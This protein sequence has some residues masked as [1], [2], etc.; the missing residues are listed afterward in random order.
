MQT[1]DFIISS[2]G[3][4]RW[5]AD[6]VVQDLT[7]EQ[8]NWSPPGT[9]NSIA[10]ILL[11]VTGTDDTFINMR[12]LGR[13]TVWESGN[14]SERIGIAGT[15]GRGGYWDEANAATFALAPILEYVTAVRASVDEYVGSL[16]DDELSR[17]VQSIGGEQPMAA[18][19]GLII[20]HAAGHFGEIA[21]LKGAQGAKGLPF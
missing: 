4:Q 18:V 9:A 17:L 19:I 6:S 13:P 1:R 15:P 5:I 20:V 14:W 11:H 8:L 21:A 7:E 3:R 12:A 2:I 16:T 10:T